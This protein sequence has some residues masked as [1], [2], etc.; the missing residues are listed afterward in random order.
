MNE[1]RN[2]WNYII[3]CI[4]IIGLLRPVDSF[5]QLSD[6][7]Q[8]TIIKIPVN[9]S[10]ELQAGEFRGQLIWQYSSN[11]LTWTQIEE[12][13]EAEQ[14]PLITESIYYRIGVKEESCDWLYAPWLWCQTIIS[15]QI[16]THPI[17]Q[18]DTYSAQFH[19]EITS[20]GNGSISERGICLSLSENP[21]TSDFK[22]TSGIGAGN[23]SGTLTNLNPGINYP[24]RAY[25]SNEAGLSYG[26]NQSFTTLVALPQLVSLDPIE[27]NA[28]SLLL[29]GSINSAGGGTISSKGICWS[30]TNTPDIS[31]NHSD[32]GSGSD[33]IFSLIENLSPNSL[34][35]YRAYAINERGTGYGSVRQVVTSIALAEVSTSE[36]VDITVR[37]AVSGGEISSTGGGY[38][39]DKGLCWALTEN[40]VLDDSTRSVGQGVNSFST[41]M[42][43]LAPNT[44]YHVRAYA[45]NQA[46]TSFGQN[47]SFTTLIDLPAIQTIDPLEIKYN[48]VL[49]GGKEIYDGGGSITEKG[50]CW[51]PEPTPDTSDQH[52]KFAA[53]IED[54]LLLVENLAPNS[55]YY[56]SAY[57]INETGIA[58][59]NTI[60]ATT[61]IGPAEIHTNEA[62]VIRSSSAQ[63]GGEIIHSGGGTILDKGLC[64][65]KAENP[66]LQD[67][68]SSAGPGDATFTLTMTNLSSN[69]LYKVRAYAINQVDTV[70]GQNQSFTTLVDFSTVNTD[71]ANSIDSNKAKL[72]GT[73]SDD[74]GGN[75]LSRGFCWDTLSGPDTT[76]TFELSGNGLGSFSLEISQ[77]D[78]ATQYYYKAF[79]INEAGISYGAE[80]HFNTLAEL[81]VINEIDSLETTDHSVLI[82]SRIESDGGGTISAAGICWSTQADPNL[83][84][85]TSASVDI[86]GNFTARAEELNPDTYYYFRAYATNEIGT[87]YSDQITLV[88]KPAGYHLFQP[89]YTYNV[90]SDFQGWTNLFPNFG[91]S[92][93]GYSGITY[94][95]DDERVYI[96]GNNA[97]AIWVANA[98]GSSSWKD[99]DPES[100]YIRTIDLDGY[101]DPE[102]ITYLGNSWFMI[103]E[104]GLREVSFTKISNE[105][106]KIDKSTASVIVDPTTLFPSSHA[107]NAYRRMEGIA[108]D[109]HNQ[110]IYAL[111]EI[112]INN[113]P[114]LYCWDWNFENESI[115]ADSRIEVTDSF[116][117][118][119]SNW[120]EGSDLFFLPLLNRLYVV[121]GHDDKLAEYYCPHPDSSSYGKLIG[122]RQLPRSNGISGNNLGDCE[123]IC[124]SPDGRYIYLCFEDQGFGYAP[125]PFIWYKQDNNLPPSLYPFK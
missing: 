111:C 78:M 46:G 44:L 28:R 104:E 62:S 77:L 64:W 37:S 87:T 48:S 31:G 95:W 2:H 98:P 91:S 80:L 117:G 124:L 45:S 102:G 123:G 120:D 79:S 15:P 50:I 47:L 65:S 108:Y 100:N 1:L 7:G 13:T 29:G 94:N 74:G 20:A 83:E 12:W 14:N 32:E 119:A 49:I 61:L 97:R 115:V 66:G 24:F 85:S 57:A 112:G 71:S 84:D 17:N 92:G 109:F 125:V 86:T 82:K 88:T 41:E 33:S 19:G 122:S 96:V 25:A 53:G 58:Y 81:P 6:P 10:I 30:M 9:T 114:R 116:E 22:Q 72:F 52:M 36:I 118:L 4:A 16:I 106:N 59:G 54:F 34:Y 21:D 93:N 75:I 63:S 89:A 68:T 11:G 56:F 26:E 113:H 121:S 73:I 8:G 99:N 23:F 5:S 39:T 27:I 38:I 70:Y 40:P 110:K 101:I 103:A 69:T 35:Y 3:I 76:R 60:A 90:R 42:N 105:T 18:I 43:N 55:Q 67:S 107:L 51:S